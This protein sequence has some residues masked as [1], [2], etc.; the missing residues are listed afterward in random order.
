LSGLID[1]PRAGSL[2]PFRAGAAASPVA[3][4][5]GD[6]VVLEFGDRGQ[7]VEQ[8]PPGRR[9]GVDRLVLHDQV[10]AALVQVSGDAHQVA[11]RPADPVQLRHHQHVAV[12]AGTRG[13]HPTAAG[14]PACR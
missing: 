8:H 14:W 13:R 2:P 12:R 1:W 7:H 6:P 3:G 4:P 9:G 11:D 5:L 10:H